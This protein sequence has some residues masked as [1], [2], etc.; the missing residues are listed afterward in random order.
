MNEE[1]QIKIKSPLLRPG[2]EVTTWVSRKYL[3]PV[4]IDLM[5][6]IRTYNAH[7]RDDPQEN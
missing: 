7:C 2:M 1:Y 4:L 5:D 3:V 6:Q